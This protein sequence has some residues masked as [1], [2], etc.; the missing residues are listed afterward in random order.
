[1]EFLMN[2]EKTS[3]STKVKKFLQDNLKDAKDK[4]SLLNIISE[5]PLLKNDAINLLITILQAM[6][7]VDESDGEEFDVVI[8]VEKIQEVIDSQAGTSG[9]QNPTLPLIPLTQPN[10]APAIKEKDNAKEN[11]FKGPE[12]KNILL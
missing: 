6:S 5:K 1:M 2:F 8:P 11:P 10:I 3:I 7:I 12:V 9:G 4:E